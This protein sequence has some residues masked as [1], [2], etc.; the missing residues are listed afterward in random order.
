M[1]LR[2][3]NFQQ[4]LVG[5]GPGRALQR[6]PQRQRQAKEAMGPTAGAAV[7]VVAVAACV[8]VEH[9]HPRSAPLGRGLA[10]G[11]WG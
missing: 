8:N 3:H 2:R 5:F 10:L 9:G 6:Q 4:D 11:V 7:A 1:G